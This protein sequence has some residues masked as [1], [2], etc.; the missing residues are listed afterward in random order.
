MK[1]KHFCRTIIKKK[2]YSN[3]KF[4]CLTET[5][6]PVSKLNLNMIDQASKVKKKKERGKCSYNT[7]YRI[8]MICAEYANRRVIFKEVDLEGRCTAGS[9][10]R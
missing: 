5:F 6:N 10:A 9:S 7:N 4:K 2:T 8:R 3:F 1:E